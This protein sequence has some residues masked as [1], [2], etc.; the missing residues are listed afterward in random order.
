MKG[1][2]PK[3]RRR[4]RF[5]WI[6]GLL[7]TLSAPEA[8]GSSSSGPFSE[9]TELAARLQP[10]LALPRAAAARWGIVVADLHTGQVLF[11]H[12]GREP[13]TPASVTKLL[14]AAVVL[15]RLGSHYR[16]ETV[17]ML[18]QSP[19]PRG[20][21]RG[22]LIVRGQG[23][24][25][26]GWEGGVE[27]P[28]RSFVPLVTLVR[29]TGIREV[30]GG[31]LAE[32]SYLESTKFGTGWRLDETVLPYAAPMADLNANGNRLRLRVEP[33]ATVGSRC[34]ISLH[35]GSGGLQVI[36]R[37][38]TVS[39]GGP[40]EI[41]WSR[42]PNQPELTVWGRLPLRGNG[43]TTEVAVH[44]P[45]LLFLELF[46]QALR[47][48]HISITGP[49]TVR[50]KSSGIRPDPH[51]SDV[52]ILGKVYSAPSGALVR[53]MLKD[54]RNLHAAVLLAAVGRWTRSQGRWN[55]LSLEQAGV[56]E[57]RQFLRESG[58]SV[59][60][61]HVEEAA[62]L[63]RSNRL[64]A[65]AVVQLLCAM[66]RHREAEMFQEALPVAGVD[67]TLVNRMRGTAAQGLLRAKT[68]TLRGAQGLAGYV[69]SPQGR[70]VAFCF[71]LNQYVPGSGDPSASQLL[72]RLAVALAEWAIQTPR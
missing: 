26:Y 37:T 39:L 42:A 22:P 25:G 53:Q 47:Q 10:K 58:V 29:Q 14:T 13:M 43:W 55:G 48:E 27:N 8:E 9:A 11:D 17:L 30:Q 51:S 60:T 59:D 15:D 34:E 38:E 2:G 49:L 45:A 52:K 19:G 68:G 32:E 5:V 64:T 7:V 4:A 54:S 50:I 33:G 36:N 56:H 1:Y 63:S 62:G 20:I 12:N 44:E 72:D 23:D 28:L 70:S 21:L 24:P 16:L 40:H 69:Q 46:Q 71:F 57:L 61:V 65:Q 66:A 35:P 41:R 31:L 3:T 67:G 18:S 6:A